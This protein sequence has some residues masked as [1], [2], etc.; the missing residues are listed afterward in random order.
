MSRYSHT[1]YYFEH[2]PH[3]MGTINSHGKVRIDELD[4][5]HDLLVAAKGGDEEDDVM[6]DVYMGLRD[7]VDNYALLDLVREW[8][9]VRKAL[10]TKGVYGAGWEEGSHAISMTSMKD[11]SA[12]CGQVEKQI[13]ADTWDF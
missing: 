13:Q 2:Y 10:E 3:Y 9:K 11:A 8:P 5:L 1:C 6:D 4:R 7:L 12:V